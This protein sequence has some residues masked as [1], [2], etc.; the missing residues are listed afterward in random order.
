[1][2]KGYALPE[3][4][5]MF[6]RPDKDSYNVTRYRLIMRYLL[7]D[8]SARDVLEQLPEVYHIYQNLDVYVAL[9]GHRRAVRLL[10]SKLSVVTPSPFDEVSMLLELYKESDDYLE[11]LVDAI[12]RLKEYVADRSP[13]NLMKLFDEVVSQAGGKKQAW[14]RKVQVLLSYI[15]M[16]ERV[17]PEPVSR[18]IDILYNRMVPSSAPPPPPPLKKPTEVEAIRVLRTIAISNAGGSVVTPEEVKSMFETP[19]QAVAVVR[20]LTRKPE[21]KIVMDSKLKGYVVTPIGLRMLEREG[22]ITVAEK[23]KALLFLRNSPIIQ[24][25]LKKGILSL[26]E[27]KEGEEGDEEGE[28]ED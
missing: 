24:R 25:L 6:R 26:E 1:M 10:L 3:L 19:E 28:G 9:F 18:A 2:G 5:P 21:P 13:E 12:L 17:G 20:F 23:R 4:L 22:L 14:I 27:D 8:E 16:L 15:K 11:P 7:G